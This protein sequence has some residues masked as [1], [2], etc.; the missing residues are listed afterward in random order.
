MIFFIQFPIIVLGGRKNIIVHNDRMLR[1]RIIYCNCPVIGISRKTDRRHIKTVISPVISKNSIRDDRI[2]ILIFRVFRCIS[3][4]KVKIL[5]ECLDLWITGPFQNPY[6]D[7]ESKIII[8][9]SLT[10]PLSTVNIRPIDMPV[11]LTEHFPFFVSI[12]IPKI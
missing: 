4:Q 6:L 11:T 7:P 10:F 8:C 1:I 9:E 2:S 12:H 5:I 3:L